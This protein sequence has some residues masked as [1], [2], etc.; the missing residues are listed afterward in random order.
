[1]EQS[2][3]TC[4]KYVPVVS[5]EG[6]IV[7]KCWGQDCTGI[8]DCM[9]DLGS[10]QVSMLSANGR[11]HKPCPR[12]EVEYLDGSHVIESYKE[13]L[14]TGT[15]KKLKIEGCQYKYYYCLL[16]RAIFNKPLT[17][18]RG[19]LW[20]HVIFFSR[21]Q[22]PRVVYGKKDLLTINTWMDSQQLCAN[23]KCLSCLPDSTVYLTSLPLHHF[24]V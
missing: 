6:W 14:K 8:W 23:I 13:E 9:M 2:K 3:W 16:C 22:C 17:L 24:R 21:A 1:M 15:M 12:C 20:D 10:W 11:E 4:E 5:S 7:R 18:T 19:W